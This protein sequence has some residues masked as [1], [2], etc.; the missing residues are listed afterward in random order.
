MGW[1]TKERSVLNVFWRDP[2]ER[3][4][5]GRLPGGLPLQCGS[6]GRREAPETV[7]S[8]IGRRLP[9]IDRGRQR[10]CVNAE[11]AGCLESVPSTH[12]HV[13]E[14]GILSVTGA[15]AAYLD[16][17]RLILQGIDIKAGGRNKTVHRSAPKSDN[18]YLKL[19]VKV[20]EDISRKLEQGYEAA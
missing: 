2:F 13:L 19:L 8:F 14:F 11:K 15:W 9:I 7:L 4:C 17:P 20:R 5:P 16:L 3:Q 6:E 10:W 1:E 18:P 12:I